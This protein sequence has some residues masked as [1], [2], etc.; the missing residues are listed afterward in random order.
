MYRSYIRFALVVTLLLLLRIGVAREFKP[1][2]SPQALPQELLMSFDP[3]SI[4]AAREKLHLTCSDPSSLELISGISDRLAFELIDKRDEI[5]R[6]A[7]TG[8]RDEIALL[9]ARGVGAATAKKLLQYLSLS[10]NCM[11]PSDYMPVEHLATPQ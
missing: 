6:S 5:V 11:H 7:Q 8:V 9:R 3:E 4:L 1:P 10:T 2:P